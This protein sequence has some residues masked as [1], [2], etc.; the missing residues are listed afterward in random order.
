MLGRL[1]SFGRIVYIHRCADPRPRMDVVLAETGSNLFLGFFSAATE[2]LD[3]E[4]KASVFVL[5]GMIAKP[6]IWGKERAE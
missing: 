3:P 2:G 5:V 4:R 6:F 1:F